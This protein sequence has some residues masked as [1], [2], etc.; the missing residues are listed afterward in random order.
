M[1]FERY[2]CNPQRRRS[3]L[4]IREVSTRGFPR[5][6]SLEVFRE[7]HWEVCVG[8]V[9]R[10][11]RREGQR[12]LPSRS[13]GRSPSGMSIWSTLGGPSLGSSSGSFLSRFLMKSLYLIEEP[14]RE[15]SRGS[16]SGTSPRSASIQPYR[17]NLLSAG[18]S[19]KSIFT[20][21]GKE[22]QERCI[23]FGTTFSNSLYET[24]NAASYLAPWLLKVFLL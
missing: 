13:L 15:G 23:I 1:A 17:V 24:R 11:I 20:Q 14:L 12:E 4:R 3:L 9:A 6:V 5:E 22:N 7:I 19:Q 10:E 2:G 8:A 21:A 18:A 16:S